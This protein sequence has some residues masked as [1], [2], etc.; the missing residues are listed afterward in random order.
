MPR[1]SFSPFLI[2]LPLVLACTTLVKGQSSGADSLWL[3][4]HVADTPDSIVGDLR[5]GMQWNGKTTTPFD[6]MQWIGP[7]HTGLQFWAVSDRGRLQ[8]EC[9]LPLRTDSAVFSLNCDSIGCAFALAGDTVR[10]PWVARSEGCFPATSNRDLQ[11]TLTSAMQEPFESIR[12]SKL[13]G[14]LSKQCLQPEQLKQCA[15]LFDDEERRLKL[16]QSAPCTAPSLLEEL[17]PLFATQYFRDQ[18]LQWIQSSQ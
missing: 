5:L 6:S 15:A 18:F 8:M 1:L 3:M 2:V 13:T 9:R 14:A 4:V 16:I 10:A 17:T 11:R 7:A 12:F